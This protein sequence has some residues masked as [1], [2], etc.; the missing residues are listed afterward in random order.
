MARYL[1]DAAAADLV[2]RH[3][4]VNQDI[5]LAIAM[6]ESGLN[7]DAHNTSGE[8][9]RGLWQINVAP[10]ANPQYASWNLYDPDLNAQAAFEISSGGTYWCPWSVFEESCGIG[11]TG[12]Y[13]SY[14]SRARA[15]LGIPVEHHAASVLG[16]DQFWI[17]QCVISTQFHWTRGWPNLIGQRLDL[18][19]YPF[20][21]EQ[22]IS[23]NIPASQSS[24]PFTGF[25]PE[26][27]YYWRIVSFY[28]D[29]EPL[30]SHQHEFIVP[31]LPA[32][33]YPSPPSPPPWPFIPPVWQY[34][35]DITMLLGAGLVA[36][37]I[38]LAVTPRKKKVIIKR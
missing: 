38:I 22:G 23:F 20:S 25:V 19:I 2:R 1:S 17:S 33:C 12:S 32:S 16:I 15:A 7:L 18:A 28:S 9:S 3:F 35:P 14:L 26:A 5:A 37:S 29:G 8:D 10:D 13:R 21:F 6:A 11:H 31:G 4:A 34:G 30:Y 36:T 27:G 24:V